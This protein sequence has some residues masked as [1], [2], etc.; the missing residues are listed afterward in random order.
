MQNEISPT[1]TLR[2]GPLHLYPERHRA[3]WKGREVSLTLREY[4][5]VEQLAQQP[6]QDLQY[7]CL[8]D[9]VR[10]TGFSAGVG[11]DGY[12]V[13]VRAFIKRIR[14]KFRDIVPKFDAIENYPRFGYGWR[15]RA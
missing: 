15:H 9:V 3:S 11:M 14:R 1:G 6:G 8:Y 13:N 4:A 5:I 12:Q 2:R 7:R 10:G